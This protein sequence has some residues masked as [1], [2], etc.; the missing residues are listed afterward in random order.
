[1][2]MAHTTGAD[3][4][5]PTGS[6][7]GAGT[8]QGTKRPE[9]EAM[10]IF[11]PYSVRRCVAVLD[12]SKSSS[13]CPDDRE[14]FVGPRR[15]SSRLEQAA[16][17][18]R[19]DLLIRGSYQSH[20]EVCARLPEIANTP[21]DE[22]APFSVSHDGVA[23]GWTSSEGIKLARNEITA[24]RLDYESRGV[25]K[26][27]L[28]SQISDRAG[29]ILQVDLN[30]LKLSLADL[31]EVTNVRFLALLSEFPTQPCPQKSCTPL[32]KIP[33]DRKHSRKNLNPIER[34]S[35]AILEI[36]SIQCLPELPVPGASHIPMLFLNICNSWS[37]IALSTPA[38]WAT[39]HVQ[40]PRPAGFEKVL[41]TCFNACGMG[42][43]LFRFG[44]ALMTPSPPSYTNT[45]NRGYPTFVPHATLDVLLRLAPNLV[46]CMFDRVFVALNGVIPESLV[47]LALR[48]LRFGIPSEDPSGSGA[49]LQYLT[50]PGLRTLSHPMTESSGND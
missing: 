49:V 13:S 4:P 40:F 42:L 1:M 14:T 7:V 50:L 27:L 26:K 21:T 23:K 45:R 8:K 38:L 16:R 6:S 20:S 30:V 17:L 25:P 11:T 48:Q 31:L 2:T 19:S 12:Q 37:Y 24:E 43:C 22:R 5:T 33:K 18:G 28:S 9:A 34:D 15:G 39:I 47:L 36:S 41:G 44:E 29:L 35:T 3:T 10:A 32:A 46:E